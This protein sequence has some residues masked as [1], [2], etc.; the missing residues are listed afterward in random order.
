MTHAMKEISTG[1][2]TSVHKTEFLVLGMDL[3]GIT[4]SH[5]G[6]LY[7]EQCSKVSSL[8]KG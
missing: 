6:N 5:N 4:F 2:W 8:L 3:I 1:K 7:I